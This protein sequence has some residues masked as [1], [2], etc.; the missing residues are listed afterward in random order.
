[1]GEILISNNMNLAAKETPF[2]P[3]PLMINSILTPSPLLPP[4][5]DDWF[6]PDPLTSPAPPPLI[7][8]SILTPSPL[9]PPSAD[10]WFNP[11]PWPPPDVEHAHSLGGVDLVAADRNQ[12]YLHR[13]NIHRDFPYSLQLPMTSSPCKN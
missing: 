12:I 7:I 2:P 8:G 4:S 1:M 6:Y 13:I 11:D 10:N 3:P 5:T 9:L